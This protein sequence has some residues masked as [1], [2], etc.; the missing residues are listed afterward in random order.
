MIRFPSESQK[1]DNHAALTTY[2]QQAMVPRLTAS[3]FSCR[4][5][6]NPDPCS[7]PFLIAK[8]HDGDGLPNLLH[9]GHGDVV[10]GQSEGWR[11]G[12]APF[13]L[14]REGGRLYRRGTADNKG[15]HLINIAAM[16]AV[17]A[18]RGHLEFNATW[19]IET[20][21]ETGSAGLPHSYRGCS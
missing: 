20:S 11:A 12:L 21:E 14:T 5:A 17:L 15:Q 7:G 6:A 13:E 4:I 16:E 9:Y 2:L 18:T 10:H 3:G 8:R 1:P 19:V